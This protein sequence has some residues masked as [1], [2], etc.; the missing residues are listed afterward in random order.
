[1]RKLEIF[2][3]LNKYINV[4]FYYI[5]ESDDYFI[6]VN[7]VFISVFE[8]FFVIQNTDGET[9]HCLYNIAFYTHLIN[10]CLIAL[11]SF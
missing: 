7:F 8:I 3:G 2:V 9:K 5:I 11:W 6:V 1:V 4:I 10:A